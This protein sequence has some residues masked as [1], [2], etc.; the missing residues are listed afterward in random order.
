MYLQGSGI[1]RI[2]RGAFGKAVNRN[3]NGLFFAYSVY[4]TKHVSHGA[5]VTCREDSGW[6]KCFTAQNGEN[7]T[8]QNRWTRISTVCF[9]MCFVSVFFNG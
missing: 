2:A 1:C 3:E 9:H 6:K 4:D 7:R 8:E 5:A